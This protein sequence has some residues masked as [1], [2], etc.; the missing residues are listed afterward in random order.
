MDVAILTELPEQWQDNRRAWSL[1]VEASL[2]H[3]GFCR[4]SLTDVLNETTQ[5]EDMK[6]VLSSLC[7]DNWTQEVKSIEASQFIPS[8]SFVE[9]LTGNPAIHNVFSQLVP[10]H[11]SEETYFKNIGSKWTLLRHSERTVQLV[12]LVRP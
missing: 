10:E 2:S 7:G 6:E 1:A 11:I 5:H 9:W 8:E 3:E 4:L 12:E